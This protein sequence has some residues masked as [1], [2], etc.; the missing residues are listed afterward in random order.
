MGDSVYQPEGGVSGIGSMWVRRA[1]I[2][3][4]FQAFDVFLGVDRDVILADLVERV[5][6]VLLDVVQADQDH[7]EENRRQR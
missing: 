3:F 6:Q 4:Q 5:L 1:S 2:L 7:R